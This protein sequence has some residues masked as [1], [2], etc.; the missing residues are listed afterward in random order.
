MT[1]PDQT[2]SSGIDPSQFD[3]SSSPDSLAARMAEDQQKNAT[4]D[5]PLLDA[6]G[7]AADVGFEVASEG[8]GAVL[9]GAAEVASAGLEIG[10]EVVGVAAEAAGGCLS[11]CCVLLVLLFMGA[12]AAIACAW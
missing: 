5:S 8:A 3:F 9:E 11:G 7:N 6:A 4:G 10:G 1:P 12:S 2:P